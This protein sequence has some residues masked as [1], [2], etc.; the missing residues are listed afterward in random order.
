[1][2]RSAFDD[3]NISWRRLDGVD[4]LAFSIL[5]IDATNR[6]AHVLFKFD[7]L[8]QIILHRHR[9]LNK[10]FVIQGEHRLYEPDGRLKDARPVGRYTVTPPSDEPHREGGGDRDAIVLFAIYGDNDPVY[11]LLDD[12]QNIVSALRFD[13]FVALN[14][15]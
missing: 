3:T 5:D 6:I 13:D 1:M 8:R 10:T 11:E 12:A 9:S 14:A 4:H 7:A 2:P 15:Q